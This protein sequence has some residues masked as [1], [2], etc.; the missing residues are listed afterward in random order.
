MYS[1]WEQILGIYL[2]IYIMITSLKLGQSYDCPS[3]SGVI[4]MYMG[5]IARY[6]TTP[7]HGKTRTMKYICSDMMPIHN[8]DLMGKSKCVGYDNM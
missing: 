1:F 3:Y 6:I 4:L 7:K 2:P 5:K 8:P